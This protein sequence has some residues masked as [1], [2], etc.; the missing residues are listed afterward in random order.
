MMELGLQP[1]AVWTEQSDEKW[2]VWGRLPSGELQ[3][4]DGPFDTY[5]GAHEKLYRLHQ[6]ALAHTGLVNERS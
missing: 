5:S 3:L 4:L 6:W 1:G 2:F